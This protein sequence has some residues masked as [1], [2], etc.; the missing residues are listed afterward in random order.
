M[1]KVTSLQGLQAEGENARESGKYMPLFAFRRLRVF[2]FRVFC[3]RLITETGMSG[4]AFEKSATGGRLIKAAG[5]W[6]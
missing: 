1:K 2:T 4:S 6:A 5:E 3:G